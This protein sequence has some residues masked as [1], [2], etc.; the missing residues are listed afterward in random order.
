MYFIDPR[1]I[2][3][4]H[5]RLLL[6]RIP[7]PTS[8]KYLR[9][10]N[11]QEFET[12]REA[13]IALGL[14]ID[15]EE[16]FNCINEASSSF[17]PQQLRSLFATILVHANPSNPERIWAQYQNHFSE[18][19][20]GDEFTCLRRLDQLL[21]QMNS[22]LTFFPT[23]P[24]IEDEEPR[25]PYLLASEMDYN[26]D[27]QREIVSSLTSSFNDEQNSVFAQIVDDL[28]SESN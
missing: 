12:Y 4:F 27:E 3:L 13:A 25:M 9:T 14:C 1:N 2:E 23:M 19:L 10:I 28:N 22:S 5:L 20:N 17:M 11:G 21:R 8:F 7:S 18:D 15:A 26:V 24:Q 6:L 16:Y